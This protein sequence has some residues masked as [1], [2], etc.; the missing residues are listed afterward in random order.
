MLPYEDY[1]CQNTLRVISL[2]NNLLTRMSN[3]NFITCF[4]IEI[5]CLNC[6][7]LGYDDTYTWPV[8]IGII[9]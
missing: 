8:D 7:L 9:G 2:V 4:F 6:V 1:K 5:S 3:L